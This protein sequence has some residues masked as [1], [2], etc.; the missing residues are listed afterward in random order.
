MFMATEGREGRSGLE[1]GLAGFQFQG[2]W[3]SS[4]VVSVPLSR[5]KTNGK[6][7]LHV[8]SKRATRQWSLRCWTGARLCRPRPAAARGQLPTPSNFPRAAAGLRH[9]RAPHG[10]APGARLCRP[11]PTAARGPHPTPSNF[12]RAAAGL[13]LS[14][15]IHVWSAV[16]CH[17]FVQATCRRRAAGRCLSGGHSARWTRPG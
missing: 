14:R 16:T 17:R 7:P 10:V 4:L 1:S 8:A 11:R 9:S 6:Q 5:P 2:V 3:K 15:A 12:P 13:R